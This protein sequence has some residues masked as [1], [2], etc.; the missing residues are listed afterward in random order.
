MGNRPTTRHGKLM[1]SFRRRGD[2]Y[3]Q[4]LVIHIFHDV[5]VLTCLGRRFTTL[6]QG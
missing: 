5:A 3:V 1:L 2:D 4:K 6:K